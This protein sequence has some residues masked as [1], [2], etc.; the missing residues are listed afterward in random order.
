MRKTLNGSDFLIK[1][2]TV[3]EEKHNQTF[4]SQMEL[5]KWF[6]QFLDNCIQYME[7]LEAMKIHE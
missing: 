4:G 7:V 6:Q 5:S 1:D 2:L 3:G